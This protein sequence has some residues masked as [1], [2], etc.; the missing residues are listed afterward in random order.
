MTTYQ[1]GGR[2]YTA[3]GDPDPADGTTGTIDTVHAD[4][5]DGIDIALASGFEPEDT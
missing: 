5:G 3:T 4:Y 2:V 1:P